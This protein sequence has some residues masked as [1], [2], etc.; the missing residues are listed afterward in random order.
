MGERT[1]ALCSGRGWGRAVQRDSMGAAE[2][3]QG[4]D[5]HAR[6]GHAC[7]CS[8]LKGDDWPPLLRPVAEWFIACHH[9][10]R[11]AA[12]G[13]GGHGPGVRVTRPC[14]CAPPVPLTLVPLHLCTSAPLHLWR[15]TSNQPT[16]TT[17]AWTAPGVTAGAR[18]RP[19]RSSGRCCAAS[20]STARGSMTWPG[21]PPASSCWRPATAAPCMPSPAEGC[22]VPG[23]AWRPR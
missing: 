14:P 18:P 20:T 22:W 15:A 8:W 3:R 12:G 9:H 10:G 16:A 17:Q 23:G 11:L 13:Q 1:Q 5:H 2:L 7:A 21:R 4:I 19:Y 6:H